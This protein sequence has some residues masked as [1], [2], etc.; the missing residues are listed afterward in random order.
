M[1]SVIIPTLNAEERLAACLTALVPAVVEGLIREVTLVDGGSIDR[2]LKIADQA[3]V[4]V[5]SSEPGRGVQLKAG[6]RRARQPWLLFLHADC[7]LST[8]WDVEVADFI[9]RVDLGRLPQ[10]AATF[11]FALDDFGTAPRL[12][13]RAVSLR[14]SLLGLPY[15]DQGLLISRRLYDEIGGFKPMPLMEDVD[16]VRRLGRRR[17]HR[18]RA[19]ALTSASRGDRPC[20]STRPS[21]A[22]PSSRLP[23]PPLPCSASTGASPSR[24]AECPPRLP[25]RDFT[26]SRSAAPR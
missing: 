14:N 15:G 26:R 5:M 21:H 2:T 12:L 6:A 19:T 16:I 24:R 9:E 7:V 1:I 23:P 22:A 8:G 20:R 11:R 3:G 25:P 17:L 10:S 18:L 13:E 4:D